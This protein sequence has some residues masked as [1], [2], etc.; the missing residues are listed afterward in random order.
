MK[1]MGGG[2]PQ[3]R[4]GCPDESRGRRQTQMTESGGRPKKASPTKAGCGAERS[5]FQRGG[6]LVPFQLKETNF[7]NFG[8]NPLK[9][10]CA[11]FHRKKLERH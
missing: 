9:T 4:A 6:I 7:G 5:D 11:E 1:I 10:I 2:V 8:A 3:N